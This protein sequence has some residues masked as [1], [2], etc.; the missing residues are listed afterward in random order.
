[1]VRRTVGPSRLCRK[2]S[3]RQSVLMTVLGLM[4]ATVRSLGSL[5]NMPAL[6]G[7]MMEASSR[8]FGFVTLAMAMFALARS[9]ISCTQALRTWRQ[10]WRKSKI[11]AINRAQR[12]GQ[13]TGHR[14]PSVQGFFHRCS[15]R[16]WAPDRFVLAR[17][18]SV[19]RAKHEAGRN[20][21]KGPSKVLL[22]S[23]PHTP[24]CTGSFVPFAYAWY[25]GVWH[26]GI[27]LGAL[28]RLNVTPG[29]RP[30]DRRAADF[31]A[32]ICPFPSVISSC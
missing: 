20:L 27:L 11:C 17:R 16:G 5:F 24:R 4:M 32:S 8:G 15:A 22:T 21:A 12:L 1:M 30:Y 28:S 6:T 10:R 13:A 31:L 29:P 7:G 9:D 3:G 19:I 25:P 18:S 14:S 2:R 23:K 26:D